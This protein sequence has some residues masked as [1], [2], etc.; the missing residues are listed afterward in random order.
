MVERRQHPSNRTRP[1]RPADGFDLARLSEE[2]GDYDVAPA[3]CKSLAEIRFETEPPNLEDEPENQD[4]SSHGPPPRFTVLELMIF[5]T[6]AAVGLSAV[7]WM[8]PGYFAGVAG[9][10]A[11][12]AL[13]MGGAQKSKNTVARLFIWG[14][15]TVYVFAAVGAVVLHWQG[16]TEDV[17]PSE[18]RNAR[19]RQ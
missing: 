6:F 1:L 7:R 14:V 11:F 2:G 4:L 15:V 12:V 5:V 10:V 17:G 18:E 13:L 9:I 3:E 8:P 19:T 16:K